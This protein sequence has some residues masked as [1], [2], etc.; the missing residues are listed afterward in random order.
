MINSKTCASAQ[1]LNG[2]GI[3]RSVAVYDGRA[4]LGLVLNRGKLG[5]EALDPDQYSLGVFPTQREAVA[6]FS[7]IGEGR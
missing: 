4:C 7:K 3:L 2:H 1:R 6:A 5:F